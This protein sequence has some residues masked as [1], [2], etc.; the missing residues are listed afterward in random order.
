MKHNKKLFLLDSYALIYRAFFAFSKS[1]RIN[2][3][4]MD[5]SAIF[6][7]TNILLELITSW[8]MNVLFVTIKYVVTN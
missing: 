8:R 2:S 3:K 4:G 1:P 7:F 6:G 5:T